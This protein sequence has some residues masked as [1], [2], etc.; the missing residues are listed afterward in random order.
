[1][2]LVPYRTRTESRDWTTWMFWTLFLSFLDW[3]DRISNQACPYH[4]Y[5]PNY[6]QL[7]GCFSKLIAPALSHEMWSHEFSFKVSTGMNNSDSS[8]VA[9]EQYSQHACTFR[10][11]ERD[12]PT[13]LL[14][15]ISL[16]YGRSQ[17]LSLWY[18]YEQ[19]RCLISCFWM[20][21]SYLS[22]SVQLQSIQKIAK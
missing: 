20:L 2:Y 17:D 22:E 16:R 13:K 10:T 19:L 15:N 7:L 5:Q 1:M 14:G 9:S 6:E 8:Q 11:A 12:C 21:S 3:Y 18:R 4:P